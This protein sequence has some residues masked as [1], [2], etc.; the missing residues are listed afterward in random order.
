MNFK[1]GAVVLLTAVA[2]TCSAGCGGGRQPSASAPQVSVKQEKI[3]DVLTS[4][5]KKRTSDKPE[6]RME[7]VSAK[8]A[9]FAFVKT[10]LKDEIQ[11]IFKD[12]RNAKI[13]KTENNISLAKEKWKNIKS[14]I[15]M[16]DCKFYY[17][18]KYAAQCIRL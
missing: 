16:D 9:G 15:K 7:A 6:E 5:M 1:K 2:L 10:P 13:E 12:F 18:Q 11:N 4:V 3:E 14:L 17:H 8:A